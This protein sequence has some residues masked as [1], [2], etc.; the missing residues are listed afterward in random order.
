MRSLIA[1]GVVL[2]AAADP[3]SADEVASAEAVLRSLVDQTV[4]VVPVRGTAFRSR[5]SRLKQT[6]G[7]ILAIH[8]KD[9]SRRTKVVDLSSIK[10]LRYRGGVLK[11]ENGVAAGFEAA[12]QQADGVVRPNRSHEQLRG[13]ARQSDRRSGNTRTHRGLQLQP[14]RSRV[15]RSRSRESKRAGSNNDQRRRRERIEVDLPVTIVLKRPYMEERTGVLKSIAAYGGV[16]FEFQEDPGAQPQVFRYEPGAV[17]TITA[18]YRTERLRR[19]V[20]ELVG[21]KLYEVIYDRRQSAYI[22][23]IVSYDPSAPKSI[24]QRMLGDAVGVRGYHDDERY[25]DMLF[26]PSAKEVGI[27]EIVALWRDAAGS[28]PALAYSHT[29]LNAE[30]QAEVP[31]YPFTDP[32][33]RFQGDEP[34][35]LQRA[36]QLVYDQNELILK[37]ARPL[38][39]ISG[40][41]QRFHLRKYAR[42]EDGFRLTYWFGWSESTN[43][44]MHIEFDFHFQ[45]DGD[46]KNLSTGAYQ[47]LGR[48]FSMAD[49]A[50][51]IVR[52]AIEEDESVR[53]DADIARALS[54]EV[55]ARHL[56]ILYL[57]A[58]QN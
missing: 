47:S 31:Q 35:G 9:R 27:P 45:H 52:T 50:L 53:N 37:V 57:Q 42:F 20:S 23:R 58:S 40:R 16:E 21:L 43:I 4:T 7:K 51:D 3:Q 5:I 19:R 28:Q 46:L 12:D 2:C 10:E 39:V 33:H 54:E 15:R 26:D 8:L 44:P 13:Q 38:T 18:P 49:R 29:A 34:R 55:G 56:L 41:N 17:L 22:G 32:K 48:P 25:T 24:F 6:D 11:F 14:Q 30:I 36:R 1:V